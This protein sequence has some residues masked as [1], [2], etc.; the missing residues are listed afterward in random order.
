MHRSTVGRTTVLLGAA[1]LVLAAC[2]TPA[3][4]PEGS[5][6]P[7]TDPTEM[8]TTQPTDSP[9]AT[10][11]ASPTE[12]TSD[13]AQVTLGMNSFSPAILPIA[14]GTE[15][16]FSND[17][18]LP[19]TVTH[20]TGGQPVDDPAFDQPISDGG[21]VTITF[22]EPGTY[23]VTCKIHPEMQMTVIVEG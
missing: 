20:G 14:A 17:S 8:A 4:T 3:T 5:P 16:T 10:E 12:A 19:H 15:V 23:E 7:T 21:T 22:D 6:S 9:T 18:G 13:E 11:S 1:A 2:A